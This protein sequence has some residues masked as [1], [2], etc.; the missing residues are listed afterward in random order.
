MVVSA[1]VVPPDFSPRAFATLLAILALSAGTFAALVRRWTTARYRYA[2]SD[3]AKENHFRFQRTCTPPQP[4]IGDIKVPLR[5]AICLS[6]DETSILA[7]E[8][9]SDANDPARW[10]VLVRDLESSWKPT[11]LRPANATSSLLDLYSISSYPTMGNPERY[12]VF[13]TDSISARR[14]SQSH[15]R[16]LLPPDIGLL[17]TGRHLLLDFSAR[18]FDPIEFDRMVALAEQLVAHLP[19]GK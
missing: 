2:L 11:G 17:V 18:P 19:R 13:G 12:I 14:L 16:G 9:A 7:L 5:A 6:A 3:W 4:L 10:H 1:N 15:V 8:Q